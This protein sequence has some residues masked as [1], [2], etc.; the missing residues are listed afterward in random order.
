MPLTIEELLDAARARIRRYEPAEALA[1]VRAGGVIVDIRSSDARIRDGVV[2]G[3]LHVP[4]TVVEWRLDPHSR[5]RTEYV[6]AG[7][8]E[9]ILLC[10]H[11]YS[12]SF[13]AATLVELGLPR[14]GEVIGGFEAWLRAG[15][16]TTAA[17]TEPHDVLPGT[18]PP[19]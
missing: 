17:R 4:R 10:D 13:A 11:G 16:P 15:L 2:P 19:D 7:T 1:A 3:A 6:D 5:W 14:V 18:G 9:V 8:A 12:S